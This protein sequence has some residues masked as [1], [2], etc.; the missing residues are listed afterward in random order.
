MGWLV[1][2]GI[3]KSPP[4]SD[5]RLRQSLI[6]G[7]KVNGGGIAPTSKDKEEIFQYLREMPRHSIIFGQI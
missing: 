7:G 5:E 6:F 4:N 1:Q 3:G 2:G